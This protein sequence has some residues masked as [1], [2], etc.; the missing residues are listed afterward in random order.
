MPCIYEY[1]LHDSSFTYHTLILSQF[2]LV[3]IIIQFR[4]VTVGSKELNDLVTKSHHRQP[5]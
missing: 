3:R 2:C 1:Y 4:G 5:F